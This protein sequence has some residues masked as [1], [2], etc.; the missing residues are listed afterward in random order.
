MD[1]PTR[2]DL[3]SIV[4][5]DFALYWAKQLEV[6]V[7]SLTP[8]HG[9]IN[10]QVFSCGGGPKNSKRFVIKGY[11]PRGLT[12]RML[13]EVQFL[14]YALQVAPSYVPQLLS[15]DDERRCIVLEY[16]DGQTYTA[17][18][19]PS[20]EDVV[21][22]CNFFRL[23]NADQLL[24]KEYVKQSAAEGFLSLTEH[25]ENVCGR[26]NQFST[27]HLP[28][29]SRSQANLLVQKIFKEFDVLADQTK[30]LID[31][32]QAQ[33]TISSDDCYVSPSDFGFHNAMRCANGVK[34]FDFE[35][36]GWDDPAKTALDFMLQPRVPVKSSLAHLFSQSFLPFGSEQLRIRTNILGPILRL[37]WLCI[38]LSVLRPDRL[39]QMKAVTEDFVSEDFIKQR[40]EEAKAYIDK[41]F[42]YGLY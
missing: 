34:F 5:P 30:A 20:E 19:R 18:L 38:M 40:L 42:S 21:E 7:D 22:A 11:I 35:F 27:E 29:E 31:K 24:A 41:E 28:I 13:A 4:Y 14:R 36:A 1:K 3:A 2:L 12:D 25:L 26:L 10:N 37:K 32:G 17:G 16:L 6:S 33:D 15:Q 23:L 9:G 39:L 8:L